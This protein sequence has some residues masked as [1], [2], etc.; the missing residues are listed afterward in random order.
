MNPAKY[1]EAGTE[2][3]HQV[4]VFMWAAYHLQAHPEL[5][6]LYAIPNGGERNRAVAARLKAEGV[7]AGVSD[8]CLPAARRG[9]NGLYI[10]MKNLNGRESTDQKDFGKFVQTEGY[11]YRCCRGWLEARET[12]AWYL[13]IDISNER[14]D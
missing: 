8:L 11:L 10:E 7:K 9:F 5:E 1:A 12:L 6:W 13:E 14:F 4:A 2:H 3:S